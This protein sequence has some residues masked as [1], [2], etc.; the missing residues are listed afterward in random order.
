M[1]YCRLIWSDKYGIWCYWIPENILACIRTEA[2]TTF[3][4]GPSQNALLE[5][6]PYCTWRLAQQ[7]R[8]SHPA[9]AREQGEHSNWCCVCGGNNSYVAGTCTLHLDLACHIDLRVVQLWSCNMIYS[10]V[11]FSQ[12]FVIAPTLP[13]VWMNLRLV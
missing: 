12:L 13:E 4:L 2:H 7:D 1:V 9:S 6:M 8:K 10:F 5:L 11:P 3:Q